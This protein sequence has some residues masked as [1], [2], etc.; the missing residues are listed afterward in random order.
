MVPISGLAHGLNEV[1]GVRLWHGLWP[2]DLEQIELK[3]ALQ[4]RWCGVGQTGQRRV[5]IVGR[6]T[7]VSTV[8]KPLPQLLCLSNILCFRW[9]STLIFLTNHKSK[10]CTNVL[11]VQFS[12]ASNAVG[13]THRYPQQR[14]INTTAVNVDVCR[15]SNTTVTRVKAL[16]IIITRGQSNLTKS[17]SR[18][19]HSPVR[20]HPRG[21]KVVPLNSWGRVSY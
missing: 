4:W 14:R 20:G 1:S 5:A 8:S 15:T 21:S 7:R 2:G 6:V 9:K 19:A 13:N 12:Q 17:A 16:S 10:G 11:H 3:Y 18:G